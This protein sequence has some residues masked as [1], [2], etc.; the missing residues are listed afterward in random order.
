MGRSFV[1]P[2]LWSLHRRRR[3]RCCCCTVIGS[4][5]DIVTIS[6]E[7]MMMRFS[8]KKNKLR[9]SSSGNNLPFTENPQRR[10]KVAISGKNGLRFLC[11]IVHNVKQS[12]ICQSCSF[13]FLVFRFDN[14]RFI[15]EW[16]KKFFVNFAFN[17]H[18]QKKIVRGKSCWK[19][20]EK[21]ATNK[22]HRD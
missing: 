17:K 13:F 11:H 20:E 22:I 16:T 19:K 21:T 18:K 8:D 5:Y 9:S 10:K 3:R 7:I 14:L 1:Q 4:V 15:W 12:S 6:I 2:S